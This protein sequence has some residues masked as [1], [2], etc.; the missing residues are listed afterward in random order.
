MIV[1]SWNVF[2]FWAYFLLLEWFE[3]SVWKSVVGEF[4]KVNI[5]EFEAFELAK[6][7]IHFQISILKQVKNKTL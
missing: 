1:S 5:A 6:V 2:L 7:V 4:K 3:E